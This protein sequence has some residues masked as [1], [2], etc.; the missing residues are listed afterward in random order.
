MSASAPPSPDPPPLTYGDMTD[1]TTAAV[2]AEL[3]RA[4]AHHKSG[5]ID[6]A[7]ASY[8]RI[9][10]IAP[11]HADALH[12]LGTIRAQGGDPTEGARLIETALKING[13]SALMW[14]NHGNALAMLDRREEAIASYDQA[15]ALAPTYVEARYNRNGHL[16]AIGRAG[17][18]LADADA[19]LMAMPGHHILLTSRAAALMAM[20]RHEEALADYERAIATAPG[21]VDAICGRGMALNELGRAQEAL[22]A[23]DQAVALVPGH[24]DSVLGKAHAQVKVGEAAAALATMDRV[25]AV[26]P[27]SA[28]AHYVRGHA[29][30]VLQ[31]TGDAV[32]SFH[33]AAE[34]VPTLIEAHYN[35][36]DS[37]RALARYDEAMG[38]F[39]KVLADR[40]GHPHA[41]SGLAVSAMQCCDWPVQARLVPQIEEKVQSGSQGLLPFSFLSLSSAKELQLACARTFSSYACP[42]PLERLPPRPPGRSGGRIRI[43]YLSSDFRRHAMAYQMAELFELHDRSRFEVVGFSAGVSDGSQIRRRIEASFDTFHDVA[44]SSNEEI[45]RRMHASGIDVAVDLNGHTIHSRIGALA[46]RPAPAQATYLGFPGTSGTSFVD[47]VIADETV[48]PMSDQPY[49]TER[50]VHLPGCYQVSDRQ[51][52]PSQSVPSRAACGLP[53]GAFVFACFN[54]SYKIAAEIFE[55]WMRILGSTPGSVLWLVHANATMVANL[56]REARARGIDPARLVFCRTVE[57]DEHLARH[58]LADLYLDTL[59]YNSHGTGSFA[60]WGGLPLLT[61]LGP[62][63]AGRVAAS[64]LK[65]IDMPEL[66]TETLADYEALAISLA[67]DRPRLAA[68]RSRLSA[69]RTTSPLF[70]TDLFRRHIEAAYTTMHEIAARGETPRSFAVPLLRNSPP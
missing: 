57:A 39:E 30:L 12:L 27:R 11:D 49:F 5:R 65:A 47:Y 9:I 29:L 28:L 46:W 22:A 20:G 59:P 3:Q 48:A 37:L 35:E 4:L 21:N 25:I 32:D 54:S 51:R 16:I 58:A 34:L 13:D 70:D 50:I 23:Y 60:L 10:A 55:I 31:R 67:A 15:I 33:R 69:N 62:T 2:T 61:C 24:L 18:A 45:A 44:T 40:P 52:K 7:E 26:L 63:F 38:L 42:V 41:L 8:C 68:L 66:V 14:S 17:Q 6:E 43:G 64:L 1:L 56:R 19:A 53:E 36:A